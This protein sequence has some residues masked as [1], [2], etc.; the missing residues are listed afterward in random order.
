MIEHDSPEWRVAVDS[1]S[2]GFTT[3]RITIKTWL[4]V[5]GTPCQVDIQAKKSVRLG[6]S[7]MDRLNFLF[8]RI[9]IAIH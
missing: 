2:C 8:Q 6:Q 4:H 9:A 3:I 5:A 7:G 1:L